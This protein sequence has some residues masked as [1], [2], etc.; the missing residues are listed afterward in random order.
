MDPKKFEAL[1]PKDTR[2]AEIEKILGYIK[3]G[4]ACE[5]IGVPGVG[6]ETLFELLVYNRSVR[7]RHLGVLEATFHF[8]LVE[9]A[10]IRHYSLFDVTKFLFL[11]LSESLRERKMQAEFEKIDALFKEAF[12]LHDDAVLFTGLK[13]AIEYLSEEKDLTVVFLFD[14]FKIYFPEVTGQF[15]ANLSVL[16]SRAK[17]KFSVVFSLNRPLDQSVEPTL[18]SD[19]YPLV[20]GHDVYLPLYDEVGL[21]FR[22]SYIEKLVGKTLPE[23]VRKE[24]L[25]LTKGLSKLT[26]ICVEEYFANSSTIGL[27]S[28]PAEGEGEIPK[29]ISPHFVHRNDKLRKDLASFFLKSKAVRS[30][31]YEIWETLTAQEQTILKRLVLGTEIAEGDQDAVIYLQK[32]G[33]LEDQRLHNYSSSEAHAQLGEVEKDSSRRAP[34]ARTIKTEAI[35]ITIPLFADFVRYRAEHT[36]LEKIAYNDETREIMKGESVLSQ[37]L[38][39]AEYRLLAY[40]L[41]HPEQVI[42]RDEVIRVVWQESKTTEG[43]TDQA[44]DQLVFRLRRKIEE[45]PNNPKHLET[46]KGRGIR[47]IP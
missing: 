1:F 46:V 19:V 41:K 29:E 10:E 8:V 28:R 38:T 36:A 33:L 35:A 5:V 45:D 4:G 25:R 3:N 14:R 47:F 22:I 26:K 6:K 11:A 23:E 16:R 15:F 7:E 20:S 40:L 12:S 32:V 42:E 21:T 44:I 2:A 30:V 43:V 27:S 17:H 34:L 31:S 13:R 24:I 37:K 18:L 39:A 9:F